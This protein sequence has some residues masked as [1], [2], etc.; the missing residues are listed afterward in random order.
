MLN[1]IMLD[2]VMV[3]AIQTKIC[4]QFHPLGGSKSRRH[5]FPTFLKG[6]ISKMSLTQQPLKL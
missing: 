6:K 1:V 4:F 5:V 2:V 3:S